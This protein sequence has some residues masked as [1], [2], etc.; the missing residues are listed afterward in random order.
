MNIRKALIVLAAFP[1]VISAMDRKKFHEDHARA[2]IAKMNELESEAFYKKFPKECESLKEILVDRAGHL[3]GADI[4]TGTL[5][6]ENDSVH[7]NYTCELLSGDRIV[8][9]WY[10][11]YNN[12]P[13]EGFNVE[14]LLASDPTKSPI[15]LESPLQ[16]YILFSSLRRIH[17]SY[18]RN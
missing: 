3:T 16:S 1:T 7:E 14:I 13:K 4:K 8:A 10:R 6:K 5:Q 11:S 9:T 18:S 2:F 15:Q 12:H 17:G